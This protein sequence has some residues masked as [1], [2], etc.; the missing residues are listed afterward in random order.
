M[1]LQE[2]KAS[3]HIIFE[4]ISG[5]RAYGLD[6]PSSDTDIRGVFILAKE[7]FYSLDYVG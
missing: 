3:G 1:T 6:T 7:T 4:C 2:L 5:S